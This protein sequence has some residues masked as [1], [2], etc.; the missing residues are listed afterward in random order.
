MN[1]SL[2][3]CIEHETGPNPH[4]TLIMLHGLGANGDDFASL[5]TEM[6]LRAYGSIRFVFPHAPMMPITV[7]GGYV[8]RAWYD[9]MG[10][11]L[12]KREDEK[13]LRESTRHITALI[14]REVQ[15]GIA[16]NR[17]V[18]AGF[19]QGC[20]MTLMAGLRYPQPLAGLIGLSGYLP[21]TDQF[22]EERHTANQSTPV[23]LAHGRQDPIVPFARGIAARDTLK[24]LGHSVDWHEY[25]MPHTVCPQELQ[26]LYKWLL[27]VGAPRG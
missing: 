20:A 8:M 13:G 22:A 6:D 23:F 7:N 12:V 2:L 21:L 9:I 17:I 10:V 14:D 27:G 25:A 3:E 1:D 11:D 18:L 24:E 19:S 16:S 4:S 15:R 5:A 26:D